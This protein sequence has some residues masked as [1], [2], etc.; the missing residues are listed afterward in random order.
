M[1]VLIFFI[2]FIRDVVFGMYDIVR[3]VG[4]EIVS[5]LL[6][7]YICLFVIWKCVKDGIK[8]LCVIVFVVSLRLFSI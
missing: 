5:W 6:N 7:L 1:F 3:F 4:V 2:V 8:F